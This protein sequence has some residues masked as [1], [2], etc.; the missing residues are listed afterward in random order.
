MRFS[1]LGMLLLVA[2]ACAGIPYPAALDAA[3]VREEKISD[4]GREGLLV[5]NGDLN[6]ILYER[7]GTLC[8][9][10]SKND[11]WDAR[12]DTSQ[13]PPM[14][15]VDVPKHTWTGGGH[16][17]S[18]DRPYPTPR[19]AAVI[20][21]GK[22]GNAAWQCVRAQ[23]KVNEWTEGVMAIEGAPGASAGY[24]ANVPAGSRHNRFEFK[25]AG[26]ANARY[27]VTIYSG[28]GVKESGWKD[29]PRQEET[30]A[31][32]GSGITAVLIY[33]WTMDGARA[34][35]RIR[36][37]KL[38]GEG[39]P[40]ALTSGAPPVKAA[41]AKLDLRRA[42]ATVNDVGVRALADRNAFLIE[43]EKELS[44]EEIKA[45]YLPAAELGEAAGV[46]WLHMKMP[47][48][49]DYAGMEYAVA[50]AGRGTCKAVSLVTSRDTKENVRDAAVRVA[51]ETAAAE[52]ATLIAAHETEWTKFW[53]A[54][55][56]ALD[57][58]EFQT[59]WYRMVYLLRCSS[60]PG[61]MPMGLFVGSSADAPPWHGDYHHNYNAWQPFW[62]AFNINHPELAEPWVRYMND[63][64]PRLTWFAKSTYD[65]EG[66]FVGISSFAF[67]PD[68][69]N[70]KSRNSRHVAMLPWGYTLGMMGM[71]AQI[72][73]YHHLY[74]PDRKYLAEQLFPAI[75]ETALFYCSF[76]EKCQPG[77]FGPSYSPEHGGFGVDNV[78]FDLAYARYS[79]KA[80]I[81]AAE[82]L[83]RDQELVSRFRNALNR[84]PDYPVAPDAEG[85]PVVVDWTG[86]K[87][88]QIGEHNITVP[89]VPVFPAEQVTWFSPEPE[90]ELF[91]NTLRQTRHR[92][93]NSTVMLTVAK[94]RL[95]IP[96]ALS[97]LRNYYKPNAQ[98]NG[99][100]YWP[101]HGF[102]LFESAGIA[103]AIDEFLLQSVSDTIRVFPCWPKEK[104]ASFTNLR[105]QGGFLVSAGQEAGKITKVTVTSTVGGKLRLLNPWTN[106]ILE[107]DTKAGEIV[108]VTP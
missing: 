64:L 8:L 22:P 93:C 96:E 40:L 39:E 85:N 36:E 75:R 107:R 81:A 26:T 65:C 86:C 73:W 77:R 98:P 19:T 58:P 83:G 49:G 24:Q 10:V 20:S 34:E 4:L 2:P 57:D 44:I 60:R 3:A 87:F 50:V 108:V 82:E 69:A 84:L 47:G 80:G 46:K 70:C 63:M 25:L 14:V 71:S 29:S 30:V 5:G 33:I 11:I 89:A 103:A 79:L 104:D 31:F 61:A 68:P 35:N 88:R 59:W 52:A 101:M 42:V 67:E 37:I 92:G 66:A 45:G 78:P 27:Y 95:S 23:G 53:S 90:K 62:T 55:G 9:R 16:N 7:N 41:S 21:F 76:M 72:L 56:L 54:S 28:A 94:S 102:Y 32:E 91:R 38:T 18:Y 17:P 99:M 74:Q 105:A 15:K 97:D 43:T 100:F 13:D 12:V 6:G 1:I 51:R 106:S 48:D